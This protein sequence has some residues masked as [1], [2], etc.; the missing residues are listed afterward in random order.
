MY[1]YYDSLILVDEILVLPPLLL[2]KP[3]S[4]QVH[5]II[6]L[7]NDGLMVSVNMQGKIEWKVATQI[8][9][10]ELDESSVNIHSLIHFIAYNSSIRLY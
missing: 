8:T 5:Q 4:K 6:V 10:N 3:H 2:T 1:N 9:W 7:T